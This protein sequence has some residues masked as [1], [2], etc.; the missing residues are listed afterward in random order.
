MYFIDFAKKEEVVNAELLTSISYASRCELINFPNVDIDAD[1]SPIFHFVELV[2]SLSLLRDEYRFD[3]NTEKTLQEK[4]LIDSERDQLVLAKLCITEFPDAWRQ[5]IGE[6]WFDWL[7]AIDADHAVIG[8]RADQI[9]NEDLFDDPFLFGSLFFIY[10]LD[11]HPSFRRN[12]TGIK[13]IQHTFKYLIRD[14]SGMAFLIAKPMKST[15]TNCNEQFIDSKR[16]ARYYSSIGFKKIS[17]RRS[18]DIVMEIPLQKLIQA[19]T[20]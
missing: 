15:F 4:Y 1:T 18:K 6:S 7:D 20:V 5:E 14:A 17:N 19:N 10:R 2:S 16:L 3:E 13:L 11:V 9:E 8:A 12:K